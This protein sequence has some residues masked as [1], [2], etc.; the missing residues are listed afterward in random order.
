MD[1][2][3]QHIAL[4]VLTF[5]ARNVCTLQQGVLVTQLAESVGTRFW[6]FGKCVT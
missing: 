6:S 2:L 4:G 5:L 3:T 1:T